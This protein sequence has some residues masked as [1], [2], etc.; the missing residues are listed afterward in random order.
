MEGRGLQGQCSS[1]GVEK[2]AEGKGS[3]GKGEISTWR[4]RTE[5]ERRREERERD[6]RRGKGILRESGE[7][8]G[9]R[10]GVG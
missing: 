1:K 2:R 10:G 4:G 5:R 8:Q 3:T 9:R 6:E 7:K